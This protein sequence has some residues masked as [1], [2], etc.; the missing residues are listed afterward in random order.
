MNARRTV[1][2]ALSA[3]ALLLIACPGLTAELP[4]PEFHVTQ[5]ENGMTLYVG[6]DHSAPLVTVAVVLP[7]GSSCEPRGREGIAAVTAVACLSGIPGKDGA[8]IEDE[9]ARLGASA[10][11]RTDYDHAF[12][13]MMALSGSW[14]DVLAIVGAAIVTPTFPESEVSRIVDQRIAQ[15]RESLDRPDALASSHAYALLYDEGRLS[16]RPSIDALRAMSRDRLSDFHA[17]HYAPDGAL[18][19]AIGDFDVDAATAALTAT[20]GGWQKTV[21]RASAA[22]PR[23]RRDG[24]HVR[25]VD[26]PGLTQATILCMAPGLSATDPDRF[27]FNL[28]NIALGGHFNSRLMSALRIQGGKTYNAESWNSSQCGQ[29]QFVISTFTRN[30]ET[31]AAIDLIE[32]TL[33]DFEESGPTQDELDTARRILL[34]R[35]VIGLEAPQQLVSGIA[36]ALASGLSL[37]DYR[38][39]P[40]RYEAVTL[41]E[42]DR[43]AAAHVVPGDLRWVIVGDKDEIGEAV[44]RLGDVETMYYRESPVH[45]G[46]LERTR[47]GVGWTGNT[48]VRGVRLAL[49]HRWIEIAGVYGFQRSESPWDYEHAAQ[50]ALDL[51]RGSADYS[52]SALY[53]GVTGTFARDLKGVSPHIGWRTFPSGRSGFSLSVEVGRSFWDRDGLPGSFVSGTVEQF[54]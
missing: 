45:L 11:A 40:V 34:G 44:R 33:D 32:N 47:V 22:P 21:E 39:S 23:V 30:A 4:L 53:A 35:Y 41:T 13:A 6:E 1:W 26:R 46:L 16:R 48:S 38:S 5:L 14:Q 19:V 50:V 2:I 8:D 7:C 27:P 20:F 25:L 43:A 17:S 15:M 28:S 36:G 10:Q 3:P 29:G 42:A 9:L 24:P 18:V 52:S 49:L 37:E 12:F 54:F 31:G 51:H